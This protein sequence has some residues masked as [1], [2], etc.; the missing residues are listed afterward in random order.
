MP[1][2]TFVKSRLCPLCSS[3]AKDY[4]ADKFRAYFQCTNCRLVFVGKESFPTA[5]DEKSRYELH[6]NS[7]DDIGYRN[8]LSR[9]CDP[10][11]SRLPK[12]SRGL[13]F[14]SGPG[15]TLSV[16]MAELGYPMVVYDPFFAPNESVLKNEYDFVTATE[17]VE[18]FRSPLQSFARMW[19]C[20]KSGG[21]LG[22]MTKL[23]RDDTVF[24]NWRYK[25]DDTHI[26]FYSKETFNWLSK[27]WGAESVFIGQDIII[28]QK[29]NP[30]KK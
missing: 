23:V 21:Y 2:M 14:G 3:T 12:G 15:P 19:H 17:V 18:H 27:Q 13:D 4:C 16:M 8:F 22:I 26:C 24:S 7:P 5:H 1:T 10:M 9:M 29:T 11:V 28:F 30:S 25:N 6:E 20:V